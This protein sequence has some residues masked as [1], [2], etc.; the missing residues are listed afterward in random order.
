[1]A[2]YTKI[3]RTELLELL[4]AYDLGAL[5]GYSGIVKGVENT[6]YELN[7]TSGKYIL[8]LF[9]KRVAV[10]NLPFYFN[11][12]QHLAA[13]GIACPEVIAR[14]DNNC[15]SQ[16]CGRKAVIISF[17]SGQEPGEYSAR[18]CKAVGR[19]VAEM[20]LAV[21]DFAE[22]IEN[23]FSVAGWRSLWQ[24]SLEKVRNHWPAAIDFIEREL[25]FLEENWPSNLPS[26]IIHADIFPD[27]LLFT[28]DQI[29]GV[30]DFY[31]ACYDMFSYE[32]AIC[33]TAWCFNGDNVY[34]SVRSQAFLKGYQER[35]PLTLQEKAALPILL[36]GSAMRFLQTRLYD[37]LN[38]KPNSMVNVKDPMVYLQRLQ[39]YAGTSTLNTLNLG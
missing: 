17:L 25:S 28:G 22:T 6:N 7:C 2:V 18:R 30:I 13:K 38:S 36:R 31:F 14:R 29:T 35:R 37:F 34:D 33:L 10:G 12:H 21:A 5:I 16:F 19:L 1:M 24:S 39:H 26:G 11:L 4:R 15:I 23:N 3:T 20:H 27:N 9:E 32:I 8:T